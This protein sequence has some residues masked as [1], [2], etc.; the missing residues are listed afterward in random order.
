MVYTEAVRPMSLKISVVIPAYKSAP[1]LEQTIGS[2]LG[3]TYPLENLE[4][5]VVDDASPDDTVRVAR[6]LLEASSIKSQVIVREKNMGVTANRNAGWRLATG[7]WIQFLDHDDVLMPHK[8]ELQAS[9]AA[10]AAEDVA[11]VYS[12][13]QSLELIDG[14]WQPTGPVRAPNVDEDTI[15]RILK[16]DSF[17]Y[18]G[19][20]LIRRSA[21]VA[22]DGF[23]EQPNLGED[24]NLMFR[25]AIGGG[26]FR[27]TWAKEGHAFLYRQTPG[28]LWK[29][30]AKNLLALWNL[31]L[32][33]RMVEQFLREQRPGQEL[34]QDIRRALASQYG[35]RAPFFL[36]REP[37]KFRTIQT[38]LDALGYPIPPNLNRGLRLA[39]EV[40]GYHNAL[41]VRAKYRGLV[42]KLRG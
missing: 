18:V 34:P 35:R 1:W 39:S 29:S 41:R 5:I 3:Q 23:E 17:G 2:V 36:D 28:S 32:T 16:D 27:G 37:D 22:V 30:Y 4:L 8:L 19:P 26:K 33:F 11:V 40:V 12:A 31:L 14:S 13:W 42:D 25:L 20:T 38:W 24:S 21:L 6:K 9:Y 10:S 15:P 7:D